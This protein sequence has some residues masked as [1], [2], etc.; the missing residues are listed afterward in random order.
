MN[1]DIFPYTTVQYP[2]RLTQRN[3]DPTEPGSTAVGPRYQVIVL[4]R[5]RVVDDVFRYGLIALACILYVGFGCK[6]DLQIIKNILKK[7]ISPAIGFGCQF[8]LMPV[9]SN[10]QDA[11]FCNENAFILLLNT[12]AIGL[13]PR[14]LQ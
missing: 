13:Y 14:L 12:I 3:A 9:V 6:I 10:L 11:Y 8:I 2:C 5:R 7:P 4:R 1:F